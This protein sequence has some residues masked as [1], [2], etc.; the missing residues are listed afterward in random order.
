MSAALRAVF[1]PSPMNK[2]KITMPNGEGLK[3]D[4]NFIE[5]GTLF[6]F[7]IVIYKN[8]TD[9]VMSVTFFAKFFLR[10]SLL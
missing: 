3:S 4:E 1:I 7:H 6:I 8:T 10:I 5:N 2:A 9:N